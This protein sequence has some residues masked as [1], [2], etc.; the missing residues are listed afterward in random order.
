M[1]VKTNE[2]LAEEIANEYVGSKYLPDSVDNKLHRLIIKQ[3]CMKMANEIINK[4]A[5][6]VDENLEFYTGIYKYKFAEDYKNAMLNDN[7]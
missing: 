5:K 3:A 4:S 7:Q 1:I 2:E 6:W